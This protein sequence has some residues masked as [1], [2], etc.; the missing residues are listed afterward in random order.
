MEGVV[1]KYHKTSADSINHIATYLTAVHKNVGD[2]LK[3]YVETG[4]ESLVEGMNL[5]SFKNYKE[6]AELLRTLAN[7]D[8][9]KR[10]PVG[11]KQKELTPKDQAI[12]VEG[13][14][15]E[16]TAPSALDVLALSKHKE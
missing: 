15:K 2:K 4:D 11:R 9:A 12:P 7:L 13:V 14:A 8:E 1:F 6:A 3:K 10:Q 16:I 5:E